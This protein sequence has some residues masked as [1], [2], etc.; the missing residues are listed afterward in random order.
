MVSQ[1]PFAPR[2]LDLRVVKK[3]PV[4][5]DL[6]TGVAAITHAATWQAKNGKPKIKYTSFFLPKMTTRFIVCFVL[7]VVLIEI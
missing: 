3:R 5:E 6:R 7:E 2:S 1:Q 4:G